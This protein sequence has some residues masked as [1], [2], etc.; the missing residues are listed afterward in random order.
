MNH[1]QQW[2]SEIAAPCPGPLLWF[3]VQPFPCRGCD[4]DCPGAVLECRRCDFLVT[5]GN[6]IDDRHAFTPVV[7][8]VR[9]AP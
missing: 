7:R 6:E 4:R 3:D 9:R 1:W 2:V 8:D 5:T